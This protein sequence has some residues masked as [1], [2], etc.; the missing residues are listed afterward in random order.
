MVSAALTPIDPA[1]DSARLHAAMEKWRKRSHMIRFFRRALPAA[2]AAMVLGLLVWIAWQA[3]RQTAPQ[4]NSVSVRMVNPRFHGRDDEGRAFTM[5]ASEAARDSRNF[6]RVLLKNPALVL[7]TNQ[8]RPLKVRARR[9]VYNER[10]L[11]IVLEDAVRLE[12]PS[13]WVF[14]TG[15]AVVDT[16]R[17]IV[18]GD[19]PLQ[20]VGPRGRIAA[21]SYVIYNRGERIVLRGN[22]RTTLSR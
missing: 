3:L 10:T 5:S 21:A 15:V 4:D 22:V 14:D 8:G 12:D 13:G 6:Q 2:M 20:G 11:V 19:Q 17:N 16:N 7:E 1:A 18:S 9:G